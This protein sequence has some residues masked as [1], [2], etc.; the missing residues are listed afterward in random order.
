MKR[1]LKPVLSS[2]VTLSVIFGVSALAFA[3][4]GGDTG[5]TP[6]R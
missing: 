3:Q 5:S 6:P 1:N 4:P 2:A